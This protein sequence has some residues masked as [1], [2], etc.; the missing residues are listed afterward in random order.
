MDL[1]AETKLPI[2][3]DDLG[4]ALA[5]FIA[6]IREQCVSEEASTIHIFLHETA[7][8]STRLL[9]EVF[10]PDYKAFGTDPVLDRRKLLS[11]SDFLSRVD[12]AR[13]SDCACD[14]TLTDFL[15]LERALAL[16]A[17]LAATLPPSG[18]GIMLQVHVRR[19]KLLGAPETVRA[20][21]TFSRWRSGSRRKETS[22]RVS[23]PAQDK[24]DREA[25]ETLRNIAA[26][27]GLNFNKPFLQPPL[28]LGGE[29]P[30]TETL[31]VA[32]KAFQA[33]FDLALL[34]IEGK[35]ITLDSAPLLFPRF[36]ASRK[37]MDDMQRGI[38]EQIDV[39]PA[40]KRLIRERQAD[41]EFEASDAECIIFGKRLTA[42]L[43]GV[44]TFERFHHHG[45]G[46]SFTAHYGVRF[47]RNPELQSSP[48]AQ[49]FHDSVFT[50][51]H[52]NWE[53]PAWTYS[54][55]KDLQQALAGCGD[56]LASVLPLLEKRLVEMLSPLPAK[57][58]PSLPSLGTLTAKEAYAQALSVARGW[59]GDVELVSVGCLKSP[60][61][62][63]DT[64]V[65]RDILGP[66]M[67]HDG[68]LQPHGWW[69]L[70]FTSRQRGARLFVAVP[71]TGAI[72]WSAFGHLAKEWP[73]AFSSADWL[74]SKAIAAAANSEIQPHLNG[75]EYRLVECL[76]RLGANPP[77]FA[78]VIWEITALLQGSGRYES[79]QVRMEFDPWTGKLRETKV[80][81]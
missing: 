48:V 67:S 15:A 2:R 33:A 52:R 14:A 46:K 44:L 3:F 61:L 73:A 9:A 11:K 76:Y 41:Y 5:Q 25:R 19:M 47:P 31:W 62:S 22:I 21:L 60:G 57:L 32:Q 64:A 56:L 10:P 26:R 71:H 58:P 54:T 4:E 23:C 65:L 78:S 63:I 72:R 70:S 42:S 36:E 59:A 79:R 12:A 17:K 68:R 69:S 77:K 40:L 55:A 8:K 51:F 49:V 34:D 75:N 7:C 37:R 66:A 50:L 24:S 29:R 20:D 74:D 53:Q 27:Q 16:V 1:V 6:F 43:D 45:L 18:R 38:S 28:G 80:E 13:A 39:V 35:R 30:A 81:P